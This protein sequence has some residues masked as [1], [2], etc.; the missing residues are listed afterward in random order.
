MTTAALRGHSANLVGVSTELLAS[1]AF[2]DSPLPLYIRGVH[3]SHARLF[4]LLAAAGSHA[5]AAN[6]FQGYMDATFRLQ[7][8]HPDVA[9][10]RRFRASYLRLLKGWGYDANSREGAVLK[11]WAE[12]RFGLFPTFHRTALKRFASDAWSRYV[13]E[14]MS[15]RFSNNDIYTQLDLLYEFCQWSLARWFL[16]G[17]HHLTLYRGVNDFCEDALRRGQPRPRSG[18]VLARLNNLVSFTARRGIAC[19]FGDAI[20][21]AR[22]PTAKILF[23][24][25]LLPHHALKGEAEYLVIGGDYRVTVSYL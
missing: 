1:A 16:P 13:E 8:T 17:Q 5:E 2:N 24:N 21:E 14:K 11:G 23:F 10:T 4:D 15:S 19:E 6:Y 9:G 18:Q 12:S 20:L 7:Q 3:E 22:V 25:D